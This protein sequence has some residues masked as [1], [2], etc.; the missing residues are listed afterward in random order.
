MDDTETGRRCKKYL[1]IIIGNKIERKELTCWPHKSKLQVADI[2][3][4]NEIAKK[5][6]IDKLNNFH[7]EFEVFMNSDINYVLYGKQSTK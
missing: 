4:F 6:K 1:E 2:E 5:C 3:I 7:F